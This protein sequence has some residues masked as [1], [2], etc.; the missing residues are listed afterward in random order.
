MQS[1]IKSNLNSDEIQSENVTCSHSC[2]Y[3]KS[4]TL[5]NEFLCDRITEN[6]EDHEVN[7]QSS[8]SN[9]QLVRCFFMDCNTTLIFVLIFPNGLFKNY[10]QNCV[11]VIDDTIESGYCV[12]EQDNLPAT[13]V[14][15]GTSSRVVNFEAPSCDVS[16][17]TNLSMCIDDNLSENPRLEDTGSSA[18]GK[19]TS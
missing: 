16:E 9:T 6:N 12:M 8:N 15:W 1:A 5:A 17:D 19:F 13:K 4:L 2:I 7:S 14:N 10:V 11:Q 18:S 3:N